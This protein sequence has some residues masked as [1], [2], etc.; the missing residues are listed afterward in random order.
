MTSMSLSF[1]LCD[2]K[3]LLE[4]QDGQYHTTKT[5]ASSVVGRT[6]QSSIILNSMNKDTAKI[7]SRKKG[8]GHI[9]KCSESTTFDRHE[10]HHVRQLQNMR[11]RRYRDRKKS[12]A[13]AL[14]AN[15]EILRQENGEMEAAILEH[16]KA[17]S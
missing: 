10:Q 14:Q 9:G 8:D 11:Q 5:E 4:P 6:N 17:N 15:A 7:H 16:L 13:T 2:S 1:I 3:E 12:T